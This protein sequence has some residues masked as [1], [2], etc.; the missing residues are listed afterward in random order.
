MGIAIIILSVAV[1]IN[2][3]AIIVTNLSIINLGRRISK[4]VSQAQDQGMCLS[5]HRQW[6]YEQIDRLE[7]KI[8]PP[9][10]KPLMTQEE[11]KAKIEMCALCSRHQIGQT[12]ACHECDGYPYQDYFKDKSDNAQ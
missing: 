10:P 5:N 2:S 1:A 4:V 7:K 9:K 6:V 12:Y 11:Q 8:N 3:I